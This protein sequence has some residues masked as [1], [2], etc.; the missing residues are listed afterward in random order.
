[1]RTTSI[2]IVVL[3]SIIAVLTVLYLLN[4]FVW[5]YRD[6]VRHADATGKVVISP[7]D[8]QVV[9]IKRFTDGVVESEKLGR[10][11]QLTELTDLKLP[12]HSTGWIIGIYMSPFDVHFNYAPLPGTVRSIAYTKAKANLPM[13]DLWEYIRFT[14]LRRAV[15]NFT[16]KFHLTNER[17]SLL[18]E[19]PGFD[20]AVIEIADKFV[21]KISCYVR[22][23]LAVEPGTKVGF[24]DRGSQVDLIIY[25][26]DIDFR[27]KPGQQVYGA[28]T[29]LATY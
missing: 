2:V 15:D 19:G 8:G 18:V 21:N 9:Y 22:E 20:Y 1:M 28:K 7:A 12:E 14:Y 10:L 23:G 25:K 5:F 26:S 16:E 6:P 13:V 27:V 3:V 11:I 24:I 17:N 4:R 29:V